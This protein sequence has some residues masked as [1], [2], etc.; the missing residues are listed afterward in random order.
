VGIAYLW[1]ST[2][3]TSDQTAEAKE[4]EAE[5]VDINQHEIIVE[6]SSSYG[7]NAI[8]GR[9]CIVLKKSDLGKIHTGDIVITSAIHSTWYGEMSKASALITEKGDKSSNAIALGKKL[10]IPVIVGAKDATK[11]IIDGQIV[12]CDPVTRNVY[13]IS[14]PELNEFHFDTLNMPQKN[15]NQML[16]NKMGKIGKT[17]P[18][19]IDDKTVIVQSK[20]NSANIQQDSV[21]AHNGQKYQPKHIN[22]KIY[23]EHFDRFKKFILGEKSQFSWTKKWFGMKAVK[24]GARSIGGCDDFSVECIGIGE[25]FFDKTDAEVIAILKNIGESDQCMEYIDMLIDKCSKKPGDLNW[26]A[27]VSHEEH[28]KSIEIPSDIRKEDLIAHPKEYKKIQHK[29]D[30]KE[31]EK[32]IGSGLVARYW[33]KENLPL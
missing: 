16:A 26:V 20:D 25:G 8:S 1:Q 5:I 33:I 10:D 23:N 7:N 29:V 24:A 22:K 3:E 12:S 18:I 14:Y 2:I 27:R 31:C 32:L 21:V 13:H 6:G 19:Q 11:L 30:K 15:H 28:V 4:I 17:H 9:A